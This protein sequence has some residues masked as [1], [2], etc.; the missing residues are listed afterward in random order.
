[1]WHQYNVGTVCHWQILTGWKCCQQCL[2]FGINSAAFMR[3][4]YNIFGTCLSNLNYFGMV[5]NMMWVW[6]GTVC[7]WYCLSYKIRSYAVPSSYM[8]KS[9]KPSLLIVFHNITVYY[10]AD[11]CLIF[12]DMQLIIFVLN[13]LCCVTTNWGHID[14]MPCHSISYKSRKKTCIT[15]SSLTFRF[16]AECWQ[17]QFY[18]YLT[19]FCINPLIATLKPQSNSPSCSN[20][21]IGTLAVDGWTVTFGTARRGLGGA[22]VRCGTIIAFWSLK[23]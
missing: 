23:G 13:R 22:K 12:S 19:I 20:T 17:C 11:T 6:Q 18:C 7:Y 10:V 3:H 9:F 8:V 2:E 15:Q 5:P 14:W 16:C 21:V 1:V 4:L